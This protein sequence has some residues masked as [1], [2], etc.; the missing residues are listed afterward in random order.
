MNTAPTSQ[1]IITEADVLGFFQTA[2]NLV[3]PKF[4]DLTDVSVGTAIISGVPQFRVSGYDSGQHYQYGYG[5]T[6]DAAC[7]DMRKQIGDA[8]T[9]AA[10]L[11][12]DATKM[13][14]EA[15]RLTGT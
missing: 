12:E 11:R 2:S 7:A 6:V 13:L 8:A 4:P 3:A 1:T 15:D 5:T 14:A 9:K 10:K